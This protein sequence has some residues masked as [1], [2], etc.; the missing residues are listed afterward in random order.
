MTAEASARWYRIFWLAKAV[1]VCAGR[2]CC[3][4]W[5]PRLSAAVDGPRRCTPTCCGLIRPPAVVPSRWL[6][7]AAGWSNMKNFVVRPMKKN[8]LRWYF[9]KKTA[10]QAV[11]SAPKA[12]R[13]CGRNLLERLIR[14]QADVLAFAF[15][16]GVPF[17]ARASPSL[18][19]RPSGTAPAARL[20]PAKVKQKVSNC[21]RTLA[22]AS[23]YARISG[24]IST[25][26]ENKLNVVEQLTNVLS[27]SFAW[28][29]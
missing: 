5:R 1:T 18:T 27:G 8:F 13:R 26:R 6:S 22:G 25:M 21:F 10:V 2:I 16:E 20:R 14:H 3:G 15:E 23:Y 28:A 7:R 29:T 11:A 12:D 19:I 17:T 4:N 9:S 24:F